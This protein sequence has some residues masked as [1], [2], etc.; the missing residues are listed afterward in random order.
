MGQS[1]LGPPVRPD[2]GVSLQTNELL[3]TALHVSSWGR[4]GQ[5]HVWDRHRRPGRMSWLDISRFQCPGH[6]HGSPG[7]PWPGALEC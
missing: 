1:L 5:E 2:S 3:W 6:L 7:S 4:A